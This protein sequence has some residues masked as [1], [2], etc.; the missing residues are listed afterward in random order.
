MTGTT[1]TVTPNQ[2]GINSL[3]V[4]EVPAEFGW[5]VGELPMRI[6]GD[7]AVNIDG[8]DRARAA[9]HP[10]KT[11]QKYAYQIGL[12]IGRL[13]DKGSWEL[14]AFWQHVDQFAL[15]PNLVDS[16]IYDSRVNMEG[17]AITGG[18]AIT[19]AVTANLTYAHGDQVDHDLG[20]GGV[21]DIGINPVDDYNLFQADLNF[22]F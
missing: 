11:D 1:T 17:F 19:D 3:F 7:F 5:K 12:G 18:Y 13:K 20:T 6:F 8:A 21:G 16:D 14:R 10:D 2:T 9:G 4:L 22:K 15:D